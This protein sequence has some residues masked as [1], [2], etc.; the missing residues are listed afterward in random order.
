VTLNPPKTLRDAMAVAGL[1]PHDNVILYGSRAQ[2]AARFD[3]D[4]DLAV[5]DPALPSSRLH[6]V[7]GLRKVTAG[8]DLV[9]IPEAALEGDAFY[10]GELASAIG[11][12]GVG[13]TYPTDE[14][15][16]RVRLDDVERRI[17][18]R[19]AR[20][21]EPRVVEWVRRS[22]P[23]RRDAYFKRI[24]MDAMRVGYVSGDLTG[25]PGV[26]SPCRLVI[27]TRWRGLD[28]AARATVVS[29][30]LA[31]VRYDDV[32]DAVRLIAEVVDAAGDLW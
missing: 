30:A 31:D 1:K 13:V 19:V 21:V 12:Y 5:V 26:A 15:Y 29:R 22:S 9:R 23:A 25:L 6:D 3:S 20:R 8:V 24:A 4:W 17:R 7:A 16:G 10:G 27:E 11:F 28:D 14:I 2:G 18:A 32:S